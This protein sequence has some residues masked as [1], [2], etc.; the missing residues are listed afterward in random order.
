MNF[1]DRYLNSITMYRLLLNGLMI[2]V[3]VALAFGLF[4]LLPYTITELVFLL[5]TILASAL[6]TQISFVYLFKAIMNIE[7]FLITALILFFVL[8]PVNNLS[9]A[10][11]SAAAAALAIASKFIFALN[12]KHFFNPVAVS[13]F[14]LGLF[15][16][17]NSI[18][19][20]GSQVLL[21]FVLIF[22]LL[23]VRKLRRFSLSFTFLACALITISVFNLKNGFTISQSIVQSL[24][25]GPL[26]FFGTIMLTEPLTTPP[27]RKLYLPYAAII[28]VLFGFQFH[29]GPLFSSPELALVVGNLFSYSLSPKGKHLLKFISQNQIASGI[30]EF[31]FSKPANFNFLPGQYMEW[32]L[33]QGKTDDRG[34]RRYFTLA[35]SPTEDTLKLGIKVPTTDSSTFKKNLIKITA[36]IPLMAGQLAGDFIL[37]KDASQKLVWIAGG[38]GVTPFR[39]M[40]KFLIDTKQSRDIVLFYICSSAEEFAYKKIFT[41]AKNIGLQTVYVVSNPDSLPKNWSGEVGRLNQGIISKHVPDFTSRTFY[42]SGPN[43][44]VETYTDLL[45]TLKISPRHIITDYFPGF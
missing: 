16:Y 33:P 40:A 39:S 41:Q 13:I 23:V 18:W 28:G 6:I 26:I 14:L 10:Y 25:S 21:P 27:G 11:I 15:G 45:K 8:A 12:R 2:L 32:T 29:I 44:M 30:F 36:S 43:A 7:S 38:I 24:F 22:G 42:L 17:G 20:I 3:A 9:D 4:G 31:D 34:N 37:P 19:W 1:I 5:L 35:S